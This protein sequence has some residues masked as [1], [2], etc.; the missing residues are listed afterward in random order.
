L[1][2]TGE[3]LSVPASVGFIALFGIAVQNGLVLVSYIN[4]LRETGMTTMD[5]VME[6]ALPSSQACFDD[7]IDNYFRASTAS[8]VKRAGF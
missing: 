2:F 7:G 6:G 4:Q 8:S 1:F 3:Y 5:A